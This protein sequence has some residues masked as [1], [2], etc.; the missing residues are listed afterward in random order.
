MDAA[1][2]NVSITAERERLMDFSQPIFDSGVQVMMRADDS[3]GLSMLKALFTRQIGLA[4]MATL[5]LLFGGG[6]LMWMF[7]R[8]KQPYFDR[9][10]CD[11]AFPAFWWALNLVV[12]GGFE[13]RMPQSCGGRFFAVILVVSSLFIVSIFV[14]QITAALTINAIQNNI[15]GI[16]DLEGRPVGT[17]TASTSADYMIKRGIG[18]QT[19]D[20][21]EDLLAA[22]EDGDLDAVVFDG[23][24]LVYYVRT[25][26]NGKA[27]LLERVYRPENYGMVFTTGSTLREDFDQA[28]LRLREDGTYDD[29]L[30]KWFGAAYARR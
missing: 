16:N 20:D 7:E 18:F 22:F 1:I 11:A 29:L 3:A 27:E 25:R 28:M 2:V 8:H 10:A 17:I 9:K 6:M 15:D 24:I 14:A 23:P 19:F 30:L 26:S 21:L 12:N 4:V 13:E 5:V